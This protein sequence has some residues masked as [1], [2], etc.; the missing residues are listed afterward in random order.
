MLILIEQVNIH[1]FFILTVVL[2]CYFY[3][4]VQMNLLNSND[5][6]IK[7]EIPLWGLPII[8]D[9]A[10][11]DVSFTYQLSEPSENETIFFNEL[12]NEVFS[13][14]AAT[15]CRQ[16][17]PLECPAHEEDEI[18]SM[19]SWEEK[20]ATVNVDKHLSINAT[21]RISDEV[22][23]LQKWVVEIVGEEQ[24]YLH[25]SDGTSRVWVHAGAYES[26]NK[27]DILSLTVDCQENNILVLDIEILQTIS[28]DFIIIDE[29]YYASEDFIQIA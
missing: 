9:L 21:T 24:G 29:E 27:G 12:S 28:T 8:E 10:T 23:G 3:W 16:L 15:S 17:D 22:L 5:V 20:P 11:E 2:D 6:S 1:L 18:L 26:I 7:K 13:E 25:V 14:A 4:L 19:D